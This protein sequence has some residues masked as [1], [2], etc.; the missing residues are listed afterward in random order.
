M[1]FTTE[2]LPD[3]MVKLTVEV[4]PKRVQK[5]LRRVA[6][7]VARQT[8]I[9]GFRPGKAPLKV[10]VRRFGQ[11]ALL[12][13]VVDENGQDW[14]E[15]ALEGTELEPYG[16]AQLEVSSYEP[17][18]MTFNVP[19]EPVVELGE[20]HDIRL[21]WEEPTVSDEAVEDELA[22]RQQ[23]H[24][25]LE[26][27]DHPAELEDM[28]TLDVQGYIGDEQVVDLEKRAV[29]LNPDIDYPVAGFAE[30]IVGLSAEEDREFTLT[31]PEDHPNAAWAG[32]EARFQVHMHSLK[33]WVTPEL[34]DELAKTAGDFETL[35]EWRASVRE[36]LET[37][38][39]NRAEQEYTNNAVEALVEQAQIEFPTV[40]VEQEMDQML[41]EI[42]QSLKQ[43]G[44]GLENYLVMTGQSK[45]K[46]R[47]SLRE[48]A[49]K[50]VKGNLAL[51]ALI[52][53]ENLQ[54]SEKEIDDEIE[55]ILESLGDSA[56]D[57]RQ[58]FSAEAA[59]NSTRG[60]LLTRA[61]LDTLKAIAKGEYQPPPPPEPKEETTAEDKAEQESTNSEEGKE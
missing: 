56:D 16:Q 28:V 44:L 19:V 5:S 6:Q 2:R 51:G 47:E 3:C 17:L 20:Y 26:P 55:Q 36:E 9:P 50:R 23:E 41:Q 10:I 4:E 12:Q 7:K 60:N 27:Q 57:L 40:L 14:Y 61:A 21:E 53:A 38:T 48:Q 30:K 1:K 13:Q 59:R 42:D 52:K 22:R 54:V 49:H 33:T 31:Y 39:L 35:E 46:Y 25:T 18:V 29:T 32:K 8:R 43:R 45:E 58:L 11:E 34:D 37:Q 15:E 24:A